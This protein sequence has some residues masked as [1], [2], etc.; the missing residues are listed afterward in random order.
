[1]PGFK[2]LILAALACLLIGGCDSTMIFEHH[3]MS[4]AVDHPADEQLN[5][6][7]ADCKVLAAIAQINQYDNTMNCMRGRGWQHTRG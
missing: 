6:D 3:A 1:M 2:K 5:R 4:G 7:F